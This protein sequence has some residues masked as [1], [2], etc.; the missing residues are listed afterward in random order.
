MFVKSQRL[1]A[2]NAKCGIFY[3]WN[4]CL[5]Y[6][7]FEWNHIAHKVVWTIG[8]IVHAIYKQCNFIWK[9]KQRFRTRKILYTYFKIVILGATL[10]THEIAIFWS[11]S[12]LRWTKNFIQ[13][14]NRDHSSQFWVEEVILLFMA[15]IGEYEDYGAHCV[16]YVHRSNVICR[17][18]ELLYLINYLFMNANF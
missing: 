4:L 13:Y 16:Q 11:W 2:L 18:V 10:R 12:I 5:R 15:T 17:S 8:S 9:K 7:I 6:E 14:L 3:V 1:Y